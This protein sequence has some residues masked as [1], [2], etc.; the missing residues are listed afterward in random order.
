MKNLLR[1]ISMMAMVVAL[2][3]C[4]GGDDDNGGGSTPSGG[5]GGQT[6]PT[7]SFN[8]QDHNKP[9]GFGASITGSGDGG[10]FVTV[11]NQSGLIAAL[12]GEDKKTIYVKGTINFQGV[13]RIEGAKNKTIYGLPGATLVNA[14]GR[15]AVAATGIL[16]FYNS[17]NIIIRNLTFKGAGAH[18]INGNDNLHLEYC[19][20]IWVD[21]CHFLD[22]VDGNFDCT[23]GSNNICVT[24]CR[25]GYEI[26]PKESSLSDGTDDHRFSNLWGNADE[27]AKTDADKLCTTFANC[28]WDEGCK[29]R[30]PRVRFGKVHILNCLFSSTESSAICVGA[31]YRSNIFLEKCAFTTTQT[32]KYPWRSYA[33]ADGYTDYNITVTGCSGAADEQKK[34][35]SYEYFTPTYTYD[36]YD[37]SQVSSVVGNTTNGA[38]ATLTIHE[39]EK[40]TTA[41]KR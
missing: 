39:N 3:A 27:L 29:A 36:S 25:F 38:G 4:S 33:T 9:I 7:P 26:A 32:K 30:M 37:A 40:F 12:K 15:D 6:F 2:A 16:Q 11:T 5:G 35:G 31:G 20:N 8:T 21:H 17:S 14:T 28:W 13:V 18:D 19:R 24:W 41:Y 22:G 1:N 10:T 34:S 23:N